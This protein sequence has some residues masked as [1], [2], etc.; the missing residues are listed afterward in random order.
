M[1]G[2][3]ISSLPPKPDKRTV[4]STILEALQAIFGKDRPVIW[5]G[6]DRGARVGHRLIVDNDPTHNIKAAILLDIVPTTEQYC[7][8]ARPKAV[9]GS[10]HWPFL[11]YKG[12]P[13]LIEAMGG[14]LFAKDNFDRSKGKNPA[15]MESFAKDHAE[16][17]YCHLFSQPETIAGSCADYA[18]AAETE[19]DE[20]IQDQEKGNKI[21]V[22]TLVIYSAGYL[23]KNH[24]VDEIWPK[25]TDSELKCVGIPDDHG[26]YLPEETPEQVA[27]LIK[28][29]VEQHSQ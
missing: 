17:V 25:W 28:G 7:S 21:K 5:C 23:G 9:V 16:D 29:W 24:K 19:V 8:F 20:Q 26:H 1:P 18:S 3:G 12:A 6:H 14:H 4:G 13:Q 11:A 27:D 2:Y 22:P 10:Y 15:G